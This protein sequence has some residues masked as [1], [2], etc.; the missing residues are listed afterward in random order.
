[1]SRKNQSPFI[2]PGPVHEAT[3]REYFKRGSAEKLLGNH[4]RN[5]SYVLLLALV[6]STLAIWQLIPLKSV[7]VYVATKQEGGRLSAEELS[8]KWVP[9]QDM[10]MYFLS[11]WTG[12]LVEVNSATWERTTANAIS[13]AANT[14][15]DQVREFL[16]NPDNNP[17]ALLKKNPNFVRTYEL[18]SANSIENGSALIRFRTT[19]RGYSGTAPDIGYYAVTI[20]YVRIKPTTR[21]QALENPT[22]L[23]ITSFNISE[24]TN[25]K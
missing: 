13:L 16:R 6:V 17:A 7:E 24:E 11:S 1:M 22:G 9:D 25:R 19:S 23:A 10:I 21:R 12:N 8:G 5:L 20:N 2:T 3:V 18:V 14:G 4:W 15:V